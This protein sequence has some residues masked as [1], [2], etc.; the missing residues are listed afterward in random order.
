[1]KIAISRMHYPVTSLGPGK[2]VGL[3][4]QGCS[5]RCE[6]C[7]ST[8]TWALGQNEVD[9]YEVFELLDK[10]LPKSD[11]ITITG[12]EP[13]DQP[14]QLQKILAHCKSYDHLTTFVFSGYSLERLAMI[15]K[16]MDGLIDLLMADPLDI[17]KS[18][19][20]SLRGSDNQRLVSFSEKGASEIRQIE[21]QS[22]E[23]NSLNFSFDGETAWF[24]GVPRRGDISRVVQKIQEKGIE[25]H[26]VEDKKALYD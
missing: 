11:A 7:I 9:V 14:D 12:G 16:S 24:A 26:S 15:L 22:M 19:K 21:R 6:G 23:N 18:Q 17:S 10:W 13:F 1:M 20:K 5:I 25:A 8:D 3:W 4:F 2:R